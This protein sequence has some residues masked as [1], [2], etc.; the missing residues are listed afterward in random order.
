[1]EIKDLLESV[2]A[3]YEI[4]DPERNKFKIIA[5]ERAS[6]AVEH[7]SNEAKDLWDDGKL[8][9]VPGIGE[10]IAS[11]LGEIF[12]S[13]ESKHFEELMHGLP[14]AM[15]ELVKI[16]GVGAK[17]AFRLCRE[18]GIHERYKS[19][20][21]LEGLAKMG[22]I[23]KLEGFGEEREEMILAGIT[24]LKGK[25]DRMLLPYAA[26]IAEDIISYLKTDP[27][28][29]NAEALGSIRRK[30]STVGDIDIAAAT[31]NSKY[32]LEYFT[33]YPRSKKTIEIGDKTATILLPGEVRV[34]LLV[35]DPSDYGSSLQH[36]TG[37]KHHNIALR[38][39]AQKKGLS[40]SEYGIKVVASGSQEKYSDEAD[41]YKRLGLD[42]IP[43]ELREDGGEIEVALNHKLPNLI[44]LADIKADLQ[45][46]SDFDIETSHDVGESTMEEIVSKADGLG[47]DYIAFTDHNPSKS[48]HSEAEIINL[49]ENRKMVIEQL[50]KSKKNRKSKRVIHVYNSLEIDILPDGSLPV[51][52]DG[53]DML[54]F[55][56]VSIH[57]S[58]KQSRAQTTKRILA[59]LD[60]PKVKILAHPTARKL[61][62]RESIDANWVE[63]F[64]FMIEN[65]KWIE[66][67]ADPMRLDLPDYLVKEAISL[68]VKITFGTDSHH[69]DSMDNMGNAVNVARRGWVEKK[70]VINTLKFAEFDRMVREI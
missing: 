21:K 46:H 22:K 31:I 59:A 70:N 64:K 17:T 44:E 68:G 12:N 67:N 24:E 2:A 50:N 38:E 34:D 51:P 35:C 25:K 9:E 11:H 43:P 23:S 57:S 56:L 10:S 29:K 16:P 60:N 61:G 66:I 39:F 37:S 53:L 26:Q 8:E 41:F 52:I 36:F 5:Y 28:L 20:P 58:F 48:K 65:N 62:E 47:Y 55:A 7:L 32:T 45:I 42:Y 14:P 3:A 40:L 33:K 69:I 27:N 19:I 49:L 18:L 15:F 1:M 13:G 30:V 6:A 4:K 63:I 54:D